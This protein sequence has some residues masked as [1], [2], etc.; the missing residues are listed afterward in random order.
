MPGRIRPAGRIRPVKL[1]VNLEIGSNWVE[2][3]GFTPNS[4]GHKLLVKLGGNSL[5]LQ[6]RLMKNK[7]KV[8]Q[9]SE[10]I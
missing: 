5:R 1:G 2:I 8:T 3:H 9:T 7:H 6:Y 10:V 4:T